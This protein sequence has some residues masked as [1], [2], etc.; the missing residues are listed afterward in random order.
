MI[1]PRAVLD[2][3]DLNSLLQ[4]CPVNLTMR[5]FNWRSKICLLYGASNSVYYVLF[6]FK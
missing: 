5:K 6:I 4:V 3:W 1:S 2:I